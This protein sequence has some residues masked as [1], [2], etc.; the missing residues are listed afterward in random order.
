MDEVVRR[1]SRLGVLVVKIECLLLE[2]AELMEGLYLHPLDIL[3]ERDK[4]RDAVDI[5]QIVRVPW[6]KRKSPPDAPCPWRQAFPHRSKNDFIQHGDD[7][8]ANSKRI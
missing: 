4:F 1:S 6:H 7:D 8:D 3:H 5:G 2:S